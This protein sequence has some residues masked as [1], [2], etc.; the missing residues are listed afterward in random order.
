MHAM[1]ATALTRSTSS[2]TAGQLT[3]TVAAA[4]EYLPCAWTPA[5]LGWLTCDHAGQRPPRPVLTV[6][7]MIAVAVVAPAAP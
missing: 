3:H 1:N 6:A 4:R 5:L 7:Q 2:L